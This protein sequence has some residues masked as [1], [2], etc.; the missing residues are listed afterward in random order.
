MLNQSFDKVP[1][2]K[3]LADRLQQQQTTTVHKPSADF[4][5]DDPTTMEAGM[6]V[7]HQK[8][9]FGKILSVEGGMHNKIATI[10]FG[11]GHGQKKIM[12]NYA[13]LKIVR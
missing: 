3:K 7:E 11:G 1:S 9:G 10:E 13:K 12:L 4:K 8:F 2:L 5:A 6:Q